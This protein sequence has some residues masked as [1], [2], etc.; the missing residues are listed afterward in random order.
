MNSNQFIWSD[1][2]KIGVDI[3]DR[4][5]RKLF[6][7]MNKLLAYNEEDEKQKWAYQE[8]I[9]YFKE[10]AMKHF[11]EEEV[12]MASIGYLGYETHRRI[13]DNFRKLNG[14][15]SSQTIPLM[16]SGIFWAF[17]PVG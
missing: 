6:S 15:S 14:S 5:H 12:Y 3:I 9:K 4:E 2:F 10:H 7:I 16:Q 13:H 8:G 11:A 1:R 17:A